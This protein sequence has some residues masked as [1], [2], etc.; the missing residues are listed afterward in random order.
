MIKK[1]SANKVRDSLFITT[2]ENAVKLSQFSPEFILK[3]KI[4]KWPDFILFK[5]SME[6][7]SKL[8]PKG[9]INFL[10]ELDK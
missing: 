3:N 10:Y 4:D 8:N 2:P 6:D 7:F 1:A 9:V 5:E